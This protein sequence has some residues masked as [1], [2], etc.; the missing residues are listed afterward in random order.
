MTHARALRVIGSHVPNVGRHTDAD[1][2]AG[3]TRRQD[4]IS[5]LH[6][7]SVTPQRE[8]SRSSILPQGLSPHVGT[9]EYGVGAIPWSNPSVC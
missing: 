8:M 2:L 7:G 4:V 5:R 3:Q 1:R 6:S 9:E